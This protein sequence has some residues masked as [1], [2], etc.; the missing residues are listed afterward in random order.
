MV[1]RFWTISRVQTRESRS[2]GFPRGTRFRSS[3]REDRKLS[4]PL[5][6]QRSK[7]KSTERAC[8]DGRGLDASMR[9]HISVRVR[10]GWMKDCACRRTCR[11][12]SEACR[13]RF[14]RSACMRSAERFS[15]LVT[16]RASWYGCISPSGKGLSPK[17]RDT[18]ILRARGRSFRARVGGEKKKDPRS[19]HG[20]LLLFR[21]THNRKV[22]CVRGGC[23]S[24]V[25]SGRSARNC[26]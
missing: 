19:Y 23:A 26:R 21:N 8:R 7:T 9:S 24:E 14:H 22:V 17:S 18:G 3:L 5:E 12:T 13:T 10:P 6:I 25:R 4:R 16:R 2:R 1:S 20:L 15:S 11:C